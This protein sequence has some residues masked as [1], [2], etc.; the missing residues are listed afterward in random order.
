M[1]DFEAFIVSFGFKEGPF[2]I[3]IL[4]IVVLLSNF[5]GGL[6][7]NIMLAMSGRPIIERPLVQ[8]T[9]FRLAAALEFFFICYIIY[10]HT[11]LTSGIVIAE[12][13]FWLFTLI[14]APLLAMFGAQVGYLAYKKKIDQLISRGEAIEKEERSG[15]KAADSDG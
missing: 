11:V 8:R 15:G 5:T 4:C 1:K 2:I 3:A 6:L 14:C 9:S 10:Y 13:I 7:G 12:A